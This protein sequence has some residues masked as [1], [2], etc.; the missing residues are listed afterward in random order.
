MTQFLGK[1][2]GPLSSFSSVFRGWVGLPA[3]EVVFVF[4]VAGLAVVL[5]VVVCVCGCFSSLIAGCASLPSSQAK[6]TLLTCS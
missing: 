2:H 1:P 6:L 4:V 3:A 5:V